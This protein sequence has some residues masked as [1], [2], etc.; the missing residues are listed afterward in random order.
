MIRRT[1]SFPLTLLLIGGVVVQ[2]S[3]EGKEHCEGVVCNG[4]SMNGAKVSE[5]DVVVFDEG[6][7]GDIA[8][9]S[10]ALHLDPSQFGG[11]G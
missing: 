6:F 7:D 9:D 8:I 11:F 5:Y 10:G 1:T 2:V 4:R 3:S